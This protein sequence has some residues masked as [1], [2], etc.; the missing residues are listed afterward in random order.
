MQIAREIQEMTGGVR[1]EPIFLFFTKFP[2]VHSWTD[3]R[4][5][6]MGDQAH[7]NRPRGDSSGGKITLVAGRM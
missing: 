7:N 2:T 5:I 6:N 1:R 3:L 4:F